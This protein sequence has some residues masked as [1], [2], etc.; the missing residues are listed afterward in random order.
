MLKYDVIR[1]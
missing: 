1:W